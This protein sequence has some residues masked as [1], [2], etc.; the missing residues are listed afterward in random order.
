MLKSEKN[1]LLDEK[2]SLKVTLEMRLKT[3]DQK[4][5]RLENQITTLSNSI[6][7]DLQ[8]KSG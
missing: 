7:A 6:Q 4:K 3:L 8:N 1:K 2:K 5:S